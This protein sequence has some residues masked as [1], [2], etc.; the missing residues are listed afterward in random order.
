MEECFPRGGTLKKSEDTANK[1]RLREDDNLFSTFHEEEED[2]SI[3]KKKKKELKETSKGPQYEQT[4]FAKVKTVELLR[5]QDL[6]VGMLFLGCIREVKDFELVISLPYNLIGFV[7]ATNICEAYTKLLTE[8]VEKDKPL[9]GLIPLSDLYSPGMLVRCAV[10]NL[11]MTSSGFNSIKLSLNPKLV[12]VDLTPSSLHTGMHL[13]G[14]VS[15][16]EDH[17]YLIDLGIG[18]T[19]AFLPRQ[20]AEIYITQ[21]NKGIALKVG[22]YLNCVIEEVKNKGRIV[23][24]TV[25]QSD[26]VAA[27][28]TDE[29][30]WTLNNLLPGLVVNAQIQKIFS[31]HIT[32]SF[33][34][35][36]TG[37]V[38]FLHLEPKKAGLYQKDQ[39][40]KACILWIDR[41]S[42]IIR[43]TLRKTFLKPGKDV[44]QLSTNLIGTVHENCTVKALYKNAG[45]LFEVDGEVVAFALKYH[46]TANSTEVLN[47]YKVGTVHTGRVV[48]FSPMDET[49]F[50]TFKAKIIEEM[51]WKHEDIQSGQLLEGTVH[52]IEKEGIIVSIT[53]RMSGLVPNLH[54]ADVTLRHPEKRYPPGKKI[55]CRVLNVNPSAK[56]LILTRKKT[57]IDSDLPIIASFHDAKPG[58]ITHGFIWAVKD[59][60]CIVK[61]YN[62]V[63]GLAPARELSTQYIP[64]IQDAFYKGQV[65]KVR[66]L[67]CNPEKETLLLSF[68][69]VEE[70][71]DEQENGGRRKQ[72]N[73]PELGKIVDV[74]VASKTDTEL[75]VLIL[76]EETPAILPKVHLSDHV[77]NCELLFHGLKE[78]DELNQ[79]MCLNNSRGQTILTR[80]P[81]L[82]SFIEKGS[83][84]KDFSEVQVGM[85][86]PGFVKNIMSYGVFVE[87]MY[88]LVGLVPIS[89]VSDKFVTNINDY[90]VQGQ[91]VV[92]KVINID[93]QKKRFLLTLKMSECAPDDCSA[94]NFT[95][96]SKCFEELQFSKDLMKR[97]DEDEGETIFSLVP[98]K[99]LILVVEKLEDNGLTLFNTRKVPGAQQISTVQHNK[100]EKSLVVGQKVKVVI[101]HVDVL[102]AHVYVSMEG[103]L[104]K[105]CQTNFTENSVHSAFVQ[106]LA[107]E[108]A[109]VA[110]KNTSKLVAIPLN[111]HFN[112]TYRFESERLSLGQEISVTLLSVDSDEHG[113]P[114]AVQNTSSEKGKGRMQL[115]FASTKP[116]IGELVTG[117]V[118]SVKPTNVLVS[119]TDKLYGTIHA[120]QIMENVPE[121]TRP[122][123][124]LKPKESVTCRV[125]GGREFKSH[126]FLPITH[127]NLMQS[128]LELSVLPSLLNTEVGAVKQKLLNMYSKGE[129]VTCF[130]SKYNKLKECVEL[131]ISAGIRGKVERLLL[132]TSVNVLR[133]PEKQ[134]K[135]GLAVSASVVKVN[136]TSKTL[137]LSLTDVYSLTKGCITFGC[138]KGVIP[139]SGLLITLPFGRVGR[140]SL[141]QLKDCLD[142]VSL[143]NFT[144][145]M[146]VKINPG[147]VCKRIDE[148]MSSIDS[149]NEGQLVKGFVSAVTDKGVFFRIS[150][151]IDGHI[152]FKNV[153]SYY[154]Q[155]IEM[156]KKYIPL[157]KLYTAKIIS[158]D[159]E[160]S[161]LEMSLL[162]KDTG[163]PD[164]ISESAGFSL[165][166][167]NENKRKRTD[168]ESEAKSFKK[169]KFKESKDDEDSGVEVYDREQETGNKEKDSNSHSSAPRLQVT[170]GFSWDV[171][172]NTLKTSLNN[173]KEN[174]SDSEEDEE[175]QCKVQK[176]KGIQKQGAKKKQAGKEATDAS[177]RP[178]SV[179]EFERLVLSSP[180][181]SA[182]WIQYMDFHL[183]ATELEQARAVAERALETIYFREEQEKLNVWVAMMN[184][185]NTY[186]TEETLLKVF[187]RAIQYNDPLKAFQ[188]LVDIY[189]KSEKFKEADELFNTMIKRFKQEK[190]VYWKYATFLLKQGQSEAAHR[191]LQRALKCLPEKEHVDVISKFAQLEFHLG[192]A[193]RAKALFESTLS[194]YPKRTDIWSVYIDMMVKHGNQTEVRDIF[195]RVIHLSL[196]AKRIKFFFKRYLDYEKKHG[197]EQTVQAVKEKALQ[198]VESKS[199]VATS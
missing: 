163:H 169:K 46:L 101:L 111:R 52:K 129:K 160:K 82:I 10:S 7:Q 162:E 61:F 1:K 41:S 30:K 139:S 138:V 191:L 181:I 198:Y 142:D 75:N 68:R 110:L 56:K 196:A 172:L 44:K 107:E 199:S 23:R 147:R 113:L 66:V 109:V 192:D 70:T 178:Q 8:Q 155:E 73:L 24:L 105:K 168:S 40:V 37:V 89:E 32:L 131:E 151:T 11:E 43:L 152:L 33:L 62:D 177:Q 136:G 170:S 108:F 65:I 117:I 22:Q 86:L 124:K 98:G 137:S 123:S 54:M 4:P 153:T 143:E 122:T 156:Y 115:N 29:Q 6:S 133:H 161:H 175:E 174:S 114:L 140:A 19:K 103:T 141:F 119:I 51:F 157:G 146:F 185:E 194:S 184:M 34:S 148:D 97:N 77:T 59:F 125:I 106:Y 96:I 50:L 165:R 13:T 80:K 128:L 149:L 78:G 88:G 164:V 49:V 95:R 25:N 21:T 176:T 3:R 31:D 87:F 39:L 179:N 127:P 102:K 193:V 20:K 64:S 197:N 186:G 120:S 53:K 187:E 63:H 92:A 15:S 9:E 93:E 67:E 17:G 171:N 42:K 126:K 195:E 91:T 60:G 45:A 154:V 112:D 144:E 27:I 121:G 74:K 38:D 36:Y 130:V 72:L 85:I 100:S 28:A 104:L 71:N 180:N 79:V 134:F 188:H 55:K 166:W 48:G 69:I 12:N 18:G 182:N 57:M 2:D 159:K 94:E 14:L 76:P 90:F 35:S 135:K 16:V 47:K 167:N 58:M 116:T 5:F 26:V 118:K 84:I 173:E 158:I 99:K 183:Q 190:S 145:G 81:A 150:S 189:I 83:S 132:S